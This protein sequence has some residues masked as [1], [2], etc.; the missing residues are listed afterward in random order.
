MATT[1][2]EEALGREKLAAWV[3]RFH[4]A[5]RLPHKRKPS[6]VEKVAL[7]GLVFLPEDQLS[8]AKGAAK[9]TRLLS[10]QGGSAKAWLLAGSKF[11][12]LAVNGEAMR[13]PDKQME[14][15]REISA[16]EVLER[17]D[18]I[19]IGSRVRISSG[20]FEG[21]VGEVLERRGLYRMV[22]LDAG[23][24]VIKIPASFLQPIE[25]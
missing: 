16:R 11:R 22:Q 1:A 19:P 17:R 2:L 8:L 12:V 24:L 21:Q 9:E 7:P 10:W 3:P 5:M 25:L 14:G 18:T 13:I 6:L 20:P 4:V 23:K 15:L